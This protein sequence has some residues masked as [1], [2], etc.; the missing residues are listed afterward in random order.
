MGGS[1]KG[2]PVGVGQLANQACERSAARHDRPCP[3]MQA[4]IAGSVL[5]MMGNMVLIVL[6]GAEAGEG[7]GAAPAVPMSTQM[8]DY[9]GKV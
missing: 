1:R 4:A 2:T 9:A 6:M 7:A 5:T 8:S 3:S